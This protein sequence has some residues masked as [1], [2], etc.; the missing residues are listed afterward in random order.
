MLRPE[1]VPSESRTVTFSN[2][3]TDSALIIAGWLPYWEG[4]GGGAVQSCDWFGSRSAMETAGSPPRNK[5]PAS[6]KC[7]TAF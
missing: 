2:V 3:S 6:D 5:V 1:L 4:L 7:P